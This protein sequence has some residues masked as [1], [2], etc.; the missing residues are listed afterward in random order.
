MVLDVSFLFQ[1]ST[2]GAS[3]SDIATI[4]NM[5]FKLLLNCFVSA[6][7][8]SWTIYWFIF[9]FFFMEVNLVMSYKF[10]TSIAIER[11]FEF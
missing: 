7:N 9:T 4:F 6:V 1:F 8:I 3:F 10:F 2:F 11:A 5:Q